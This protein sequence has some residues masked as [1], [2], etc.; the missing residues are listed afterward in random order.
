MAMG[1][2]LQVVVQ[3]RWPAIVGQRLLG[4]SI[5]GMVGMA[6]AIGIALEGLTTLDP[7]DATAEAESTAAHTSVELVHL[8]S[9]SPHWQQR[10]REQGKRLL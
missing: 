2:T 4:S 1:Q 6:S 9:P 10:I 7:L 3:R 5:G 8:E